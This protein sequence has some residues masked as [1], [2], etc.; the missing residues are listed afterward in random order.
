MTAPSCAWLLLRASGY[1]W[2]CVL[3]CIGTCVA[4]D[5]LLTFVHARCH[6]APLTLSQ[7]MTS[8]LT[9]KFHWRGLM[10]LVKCALMSV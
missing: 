5:L 9:I 1:A 3:L 7:W 6:G 10:L 2:L 8:V 4:W